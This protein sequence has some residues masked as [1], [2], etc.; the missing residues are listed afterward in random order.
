[1]G[2]GKKNS[3]ILNSVHIAWPFQVI[4]SP[5]EVVGIFLGKLS[6]FSPCTESL[7]S[8]AD[9]NMSAHNSRVE[10]QCLRTNVL[11]SEGLWDLSPSII[12]FE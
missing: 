10:E 7:N 5:Q 12:D 8:Y 2:N 1:M 6:G 3:R 4:D 9:V 11:G